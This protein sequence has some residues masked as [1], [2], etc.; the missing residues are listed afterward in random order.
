MLSF[1]ENPSVKMC[2]RPHRGSLDVSMAE[3]QEIPRTV[4]AILTVV[5]KALAELAG[6]GVFGKFRQQLGEFETL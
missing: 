4:E 6:N 1:K 2:I 3:C 5:N